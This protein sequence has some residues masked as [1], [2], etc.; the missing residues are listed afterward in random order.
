[1][2]T[3]SITILRPGPLTTVQ[4]LGRPG[5]GMWGIAPG[6]A[7]DRSSFQLANRLVGNPA[8]SAGL[9]ITAGGLHA[10]FTTAATI[11]LTGANAPA[12]VAGRAVALNGPYRIPRGATLEL[13]DPTHGLR[14]YLAV[15]GGLATRRVLGSRATDVIAGIGRELAAG[16]ELPIGSDPTHDILVDLA[17][18]R[19]WPDPVVIDVVE[20]PRAESFSAPAFHVLVTGDYVVSP[21]SNRIGIRFT[22]P[23]VQH[24]SHGDLPSEPAFRGALEVPP[25]GQPILLMTDHPTTCGYP[26]IGVAEPRSTDAAAQLRPGQHVSFRLLQPDVV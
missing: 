8:D 19:W 6:G 3:G 4:D 7:A 17:P 16:D 26:V 12:S 13:G 18:T 25:D 1:M 15:R 23:P 22:G 20:G 11:A 9:E 2:T 5:Y 14:T 10:T 24:R 21:N